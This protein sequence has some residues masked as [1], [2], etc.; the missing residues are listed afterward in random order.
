MRF[1]LAGAGDGDKA[2]AGPRSGKIFLF[3][4]SKEPEIVAII[5]DY[6]DRLCFHFLLGGTSTWAGHNFLLCHFSVPT[7]KPFLSRLLKIPM[8]AEMLLCPWSRLSSLFAP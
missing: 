8:L 2:E 6:F 3:S 5:H 1:H 7:F 4:V